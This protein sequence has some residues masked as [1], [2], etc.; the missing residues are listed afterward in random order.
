MTILVYKGVELRLVWSFYMESGE[1]SLS[2][3]RDENG[4][5]WLTA[6]VALWPPAP[7]AADG[8]MWLKTWSECDGLPEALEEAGIVE[9][10]H[11]VHPTG[12]C[13]ARLAKLT[14]TAIA[15]RDAQSHPEK[16]MAQAEA[17]AIAKVQGR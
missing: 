10:T 12:Y 13:V 5:P 15:D 16:A 7:V 2:L 8:E 11:R 1:D 14:P 4:E 3:V 6:S 9:L 17:R